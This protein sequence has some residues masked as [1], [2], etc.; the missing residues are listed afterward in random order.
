MDTKKYMLQGW[1][2]YLHTLHHPGGVPMVLL[3]KC[4]EYPIENITKSE[5]SHCHS[6][7]VN[8]DLHVTDLAVS[9]TTL[10]STAPSKI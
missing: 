4:S 6:F 7:G 1:L 2:A 9:R 10:V 8:L 5:D 3:I